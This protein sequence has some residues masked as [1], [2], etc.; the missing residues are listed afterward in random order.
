MGIGEGANLL[1]YAF[2]PAALV[3]PLG[4]LSILVTAILSSK[5]LDEKLNFVGKVFSIIFLS[6][7]SFASIQFKIFE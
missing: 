3:T 1:A 6:F 5:F 7:Y 2:V 4:A